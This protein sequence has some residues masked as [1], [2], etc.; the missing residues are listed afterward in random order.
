MAAAHARVAVDELAGLVRGHVT[1]GM[2][3][4]FSSDLP[5]LLADFHR[6]HPGVQITLT[7]AN[8]D[9]LMVALGAGRLD[10]ALVSLET[11]PPPPG[12]ETHVVVDE[13]IVAAVGHDDELASRTTIRL[14]ALRD[15]TLISLPRGTGLRAALDRACAAAGLAP[16]IGFEA[17]D[18]YVLAQLASRGLGVAIVPESLAR[19]H[20]DEIHA[21]TFSRPRLR[22]RLAL[23]WRA[24]GPASPAARALIVAA[25]QSWGGR[26]CGA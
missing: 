19:A 3:T 24:D 7:E 16:R 15:R 4:S 25:T 13:A 12:I 9:E 1:M 17:S 22:G 21:L 20:P 5:D 26:S 23:A 11:A 18:P 2:I 8:S 14:E 10:L 6:R